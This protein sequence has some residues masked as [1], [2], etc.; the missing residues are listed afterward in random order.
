MHT[1]QVTL[2]VKLHILAN[3]SVQ[4]DLSMFLF[5]SPVFLSCS[6]LLCCYFSVFSQSKYFPHHFSP[7]K[8]MP[9]RFLSVSFQRYIY[10]V[11][12]FLVGD[13]CLF[14]FLLTSNSFHHL[15]LKHLSCVLYLSADAADEW[16]KRKMILAHAE[17]RKLLL[18][19][20]GTV[21]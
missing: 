12:L 8:L 9:R 6:L 14:S 1:N 21:L 18:P 13:N 17:E 10:Y 16:N 7:S 15:F 2:W 3:W 20:E 11:F 19:E 4:L 5:S